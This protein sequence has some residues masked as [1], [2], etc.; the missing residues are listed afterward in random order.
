M[1]YLPDV[2]RPKEEGTKLEFSEEGGFR[3]RGEIVLLC[4]HHFLPAQP[5]FFRMQIGKEAREKRKCIF[6]YLVSSN[7]GLIQLALVSMSI[8]TPPPAL[9]VQ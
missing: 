3:T 1:L 4:Y 5:N 2:C 7:R 9:K 8:I 6:F